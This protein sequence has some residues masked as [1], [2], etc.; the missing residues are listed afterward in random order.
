MAAAA[1]VASAS[2]CLTALQTACGPNRTN[3][4]ACALFRRQCAGDHAHQLQAAGCDNAAIAAWCAGSSPSDQCRAVGPGWVQ[5]QTVP[6]HVET[7]MYYVAVF[8]SAEDA[9]YPA[10]GRRG[11]GA[12]GLLLTL[13]TSV[14]PQPSLRPRHRRFTFRS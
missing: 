14:E 8:R 9:S 5:L 4:F 2:A 13:T 7:D 6:V 10:V 3:V 1:P 12:E 11:V